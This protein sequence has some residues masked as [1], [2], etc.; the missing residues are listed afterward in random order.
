MRIF[1]WISSGVTTLIFT[2]TD[3]THEP[4]GD[5]LTNQ[6]EFAF[7]LDPT[8]GNSANPITAPLGKTTHAFTYTRYAASA[9]T[10]TVWTSTDLQGW[11]KDPAADMSENYGTPNSSGVQTVEVTLLSPPA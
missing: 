5:G 7:G 8:T 10:Y 3:P 6:Q 11:A 2:D 4:D 9:L 1:P